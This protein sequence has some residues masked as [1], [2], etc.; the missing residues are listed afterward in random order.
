MKQPGQQPEV[1]FGPAANQLKLQSQLPT[2]GH[3]IS[4]LLAA[5]TLEPAVLSATDRITESVSAGAQQTRRTVKHRSTSPHHSTPSQ[6]QRVIM[7]DRAGRRPAECCAR[8]VTV[9]SSMVVSSDL[10]SYSFP[11]VVI[12]TRWSRIHGCVCK[13]QTT[14]HSRCFP[15]LR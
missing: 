12:L 14:V 9:P 5:P 2:V 3:M 8:F 10:R 6:T 4:D 1:W 7:L 15:N 13:G 11:C